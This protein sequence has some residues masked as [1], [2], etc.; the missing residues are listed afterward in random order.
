MTLGIQKE[1][2]E[3]AQEDT[4]GNQGALHGSGCDTRDGSD[5]ITKGTKVAS[6][7]Y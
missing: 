6:N 1:K 7:T 4:Q 2:E 3:A 5:S